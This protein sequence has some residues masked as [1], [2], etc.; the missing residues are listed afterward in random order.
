MNNQLVDRVLENFNLTPKQ[1]E[2]SLARGCDVAVTA[3][4]GSGKTRTLVAR[5][6]SLLADG[7]DVRKV[8]AITFSEKAAREMR[9][10]A[11]E[12]LEKLV[13]QSTSEEERGFWLDLNNQMDAARISTIHSL[14]AEILRAHPVEARI[15]P[16]FEVLDEGL[17][18]ALRVQVVDDTLARLVGLPEFSPL[19]RILEIRALTSLLS[20]LLEKRLEAQEIFDQGEL[21]GERLIQ[22][23]IGDAL[24]H[25]SIV[26]CIIELRGMTRTAIYAEAGD[27][28]GAQVDGLLEAWGEIDEVLQGGDIISCVEFLHQARRNMGLRYGSKNSR[29]YNI[30]KDLQ[31][32]YDE[33]VDPLWGGSESKDKPPDPKTEADFILACSLIKAAF[34]LMIASY[35]EAL[36]QRGSVDFD[37]L[38]YGA[39]QLLSLPEIQRQWQEDID[40]L[41]VDEFQDT[42]E[43]Q[44]KIVRALTGQSGKLFVVGDAKQS[45]YRFRRADVTVFRSLRREIKNQG[46]LSVDLDETFRTHK[47][48][49]DVMS[50]FLEASMGVEEDPSRPYFEPFSRMIAKGNPPREGIL[51]PHIE[52]IYGAG[53]NAANARPVAA[54]ALATRLLELKE[55]GQI[56]DWDDV[57]LLFRASTGFSFYENAFEESNIPFVTVAGRG[58][59]DRP[60]IRDILNIL[61]ALADPTDDL[62]MAGLLRSPAFG[63][64]DS[65]LY[66][67]RQQ[68]TQPT[69]FFGALQGEVTFLEPEDQLRVKRALLILNSLIPEVDRIP[70]AELI[71]QLIDATDFRGILA[72]GEEGGNSGRMWRNL[73]KLVA[74][75]Q[76]SGKVNVRDFLEY[77][78]TINDVGAREGEAPADAEGSVRLMTIHKSKG[79]EFPVVVLAD[80]GRKPN[81]RSEA[82]Y[83]L[84]N[85]GLAFKMDPPP[86]LYSLAKHQDS[87]QNDAEEKRVLYVA[88]TR[89]QQKLIINGHTTQTKSGW[90]TCSWLDDLGAA[91]QV[92]INKLMDQAGSEV[93]Y[94]TASG[95]PVRAWIAAQEL[96]RSRIDKVT[97]KD[98]DSGPGGL[99]LY[100]PLVK[101]VIPLAVEGEVPDERVWRSTGTV[102]V[103]PPGVIGHMVHKAI[104]LWLFPGNPKLQQLLDAS[105]LEQGLA[106]SGQRIRAVNQAMELLQRLF[107]SSIRGEI[108]EAKQRYHELPY[109]RMVGD[110]AETGYI[111][112]LY[113]NANGWQI[114]D[115]KT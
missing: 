29:V 46:G 80:A 16:K 27:K 94:H 100:A 89:A 92:D 106:Q 1:K 110:H 109:S 104:E 90:T 24:A 70:V 20:I 17:T 8:V 15:D 40:A 7:S 95:H 61:L 79:L 83:L 39:V 42:N 113:H 60:E 31:A 114:L 14:C 86:L 23:A 44:R 32:A 76:N 87:D 25:P 18:A 33:L 30:V 34:K 105:A 69:H 12:T 88:L 62:A 63:L 35:K 41:L 64:T 43:R 65:A 82:A 56:N 91:V 101:P 84:N 98:P 21:G 102:A 19:F 115:F 13:K 9:S 108:E 49:L 52:F 57:A 47:S 111:D 112:L 97:A 22:Q 77:I 36:V 4:A 48:L 107:D 28:L 6:A 2:A 73:D 55:Q 96:S 26:D 66:L 93:I 81:T 74:D 45:I 103:I 51:A 3:G 85:L 11:R 53:K 58:F 10:H 75:A 37:D 67:L 78:I 50:D 71:K 59:Y 99:P 5:Y 72:A 54:Q 68:S 38:E